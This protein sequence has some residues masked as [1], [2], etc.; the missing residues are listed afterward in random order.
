[1]CIKK[2]FLKLFKKAYEHEPMYY[3]TESYAEL[4]EFYNDE[5]NKIADVSSAIIPSDLKSMSDRLNARRV[6]DEN[7]L[8][9]RK[10]K[11]VKMDK[12]SIKLSPSQSFVDKQRQDKQITS[13]STEVIHS[14]VEVMSD[15]DLPE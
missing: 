1:M 6:H 9:Y 4:S 14:P 2:L 7:V 8:D 3:E 11:R 5:A 10:M 12:K 15:D 13:L